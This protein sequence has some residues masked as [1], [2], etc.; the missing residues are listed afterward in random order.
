MG[1]VGE[2]GR[3]AG[4]FVLDLKHQNELIKSEND[5]KSA[6]L[7]FPNWRSQNICLGDFYTCTTAGGSMSYLIINLTLFQQL[8]ISSESLSHLCR[9]RSGSGERLKRRVVFVLFW[10]DA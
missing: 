1:Q 10:A 3:E 8:G 5:H 6:S 4:F 7:M 9:C 2:K